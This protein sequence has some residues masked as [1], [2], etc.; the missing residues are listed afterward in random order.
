M[1]KEDQSTQPLKG[2]RHLKFLSEMDNLVV[3][4]QLL[5]LISDD[6]N[7]DGSATIAIS[8]LDLVG[9]STL[10][11]DLETSL[12]LTGV[13]HGNQ[14]TVLTNVNEAVLLESR[15][16]H[17]VQD[18]RWGW[19]GDN[20]RLFAQLLCEQV[21]T[22]VTM[23]AGLG[24]GGDADDL[25]WSALEDDQVTNADVVAWNGKVA[26]LSSSWRSWGWSRWLG[27]LC[28]GN[29]LDVVTTG[30][31]VGLAGP[32]VGG[33]GM[34]SGVQLGTKVL[35]VVVVVIR[36]THFLVFGFYNNDVWN[37]AAGLLLLDVY[38]DLFNVSWLCNVDLWSF[39]ETTN[40]EI[41]V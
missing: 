26:G 30:Q 38:V 35:Q 14:E 31:G 39:D 12:D 6:Q 3:N 13:G 2:K 4:N 24:R 1:Y 10:V 28:S 41:L 25:A 15:G 19:V 20:A 16:E 32:G 9:E 27:D 22:E 37:S 11:D 17:G 18:D 29:V 40:E 34:E 23:L 5:I 36:F 7:T 33:S 8:S 21:N